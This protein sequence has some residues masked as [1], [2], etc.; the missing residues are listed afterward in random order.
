MSFDTGIEVPSVYF[1]IIKNLMAMQVAMNVTQVVPGKTR[2]MNGYM[3]KDQAATHGGV[4][5][6]KESPS[7]IFKVAGKV[8]Q[9]SLVVVASYEDFSSIK[10]FENTKALAWDDYITQMV[11]SVFFAYCFVPSLYHGFV[12]FF[13]GIKWTQWRAIGLYEG[14]A[15]GMSEVGVCNNE[16]AHNI[17]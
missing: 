10:S 1:S 14:Q 15:F 2:R 6:M 16:G 11:D 9:S 17:R 12:H 8:F 5:R 4:A 3:S 7:H 13:T